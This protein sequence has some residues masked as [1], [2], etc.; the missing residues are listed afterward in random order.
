MLPPCFAPCGGKL[1]G[2]P[3]LHGR[4]L[5]RHWFVVTP[6]SSTSVGASSFDGPTRCQRTPVGSVVLT[7][8]N[9]LLAPR[10]PPARMY[11]HIRGN[12]PI[13]AAPL[14]FARVRAALGWPPPRPP[15][16]PHSHLLHPPTI[17]HT[18]PPSKQTHPT[19]RLHNGL[20]SN[21][22]LDS[23]G[24]PVGLPCGSRGAPVGPPWG[25]R[26]D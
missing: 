9:N 17:P 13:P 16:P 12:I 14:D 19:Y 18:H 8:C 10:I 4:M 23:R 20:N 1:S 5:C 6:K 3:T 11:T 15:A 7:F 21:G 24:A 25:L 22:G 2:V 26:D